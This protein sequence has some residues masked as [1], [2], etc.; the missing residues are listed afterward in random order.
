[1][2]CCSGTAGI[3]VASTIFRNL[4]SAGRSPTKVYSRGGTGGPGGGR[5]SIPAHVAAC[6]TYCAFVHV[7]EGDCIRG[8]WFPDSKCLPR[9]PLRYEIC[10][11][12]RFSLFTLTRW[13]PW[14]SLSHGDNPALTWTQCENSGAR[15]LGDRAAILP[16]ATPPFPMFHCYQSTRR[17]LGIDVRY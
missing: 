2:S 16:T 14:Y 3:G 6:G 1:M 15:S 11:L 9:P 12:P 5:A 10:K 13:L 17:F 4:M 8:A 7:S